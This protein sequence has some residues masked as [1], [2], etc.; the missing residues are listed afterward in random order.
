M[1]AVCL[2][3]SYG[4]TFQRDITSSHFINSAFALKLY[5]FPFSV[6]CLLRSLHFQH[7]IVSS[8]FISCIIPSR[9]P[10]FLIVDMYARNEISVVI[11]ILASYNSPCMHS[12]IGPVHK[13]GH[14][15]PSTLSIKCPYH[16]LKFIVTLGFSVYQHYL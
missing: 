4:R 7:I 16:S 9:N 6:L 3:Y 13:T 2:P 1:L 15:H 10:Q 12:L 5:P 8:C 11:F 14:I